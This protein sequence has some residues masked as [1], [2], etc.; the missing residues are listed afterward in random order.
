MKHYKVIQK[1]AGW[2]VYYRGIYT[3]FI[4]KEIN[5]LISE[6]NCFA[7]IGRLETKK[8]QIKNFLFK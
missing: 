1:G 6:E 3:L 8:I 5:C 2:T 7:F 4:W